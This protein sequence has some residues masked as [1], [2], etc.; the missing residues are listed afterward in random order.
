ASKIVEIENIRKKV[1]NFLREVSKFNLSID[2]EILE[3]KII[4][5]MEKISL[6]DLCVAGID[7]GLVSH[8]FHGIDVML[9]R[10][11]GVIFYFKNSKIKKVDYWP[12][13]LPSF[14]PR[15]IFDPFTDIELEVN[16]NFE[17][18]IVEVKNAVEVIRNFKPDIVFLDGSIVPHYVERPVE[19]SMLFPTYQKLLESYLELF[20]EAERNET[21]LAGIIEDSRGTRFCEIANQRILSRLKEIE[22]EIKLLLNRTIDSN[23]LTYTLNLGERTLVFKYSSFPEQHP[24]LKEFGGKIANSIFSFYLKTA[25]F[26]RPIR[27]DFLGEKEFIKKANF[28]SSVILALCGHSNYGIPSVLIEADQRARLSEKDLEIFYNDLVAKTGNLAAL[29]LQRREQRPF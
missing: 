11:V 10:A 28:I 1:G 2:R 27:V 12:D 6:D 22:P 24:I 21:I 29:F 20:Y 7:G 14:V 4:Q 3:E 16:S 13:S 23:L 15:V 19:H 17:R 25:E 5:A 26:D 8:S 18:Q 9:L